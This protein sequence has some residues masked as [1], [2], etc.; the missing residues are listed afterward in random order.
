SVLPSADRGS[1]SRFWPGTYPS[2]RSRC[3]KATWE[4]DRGSGPR[5]SE[6]AV[7]MLRVPT[8]YTFPAGWA[9][10]TSGAAMPASRRLGGS[11]RAPGLPPRSVEAQHRPRALAGL[12]R[13]E[14]LVDVLEAAAP[15]PH[16]V[17][18][19][20][21]LPVELQIARDVDAEAIRS[22]PRRL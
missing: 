12:H 5:R 18:Q 21:A 19:H 6:M 22:H 14:R 13:P 11:T 10:A 15:R 4:R 1:R 20:P 16:L 17:E 2:S 9:S 7:A 8:R 3:S